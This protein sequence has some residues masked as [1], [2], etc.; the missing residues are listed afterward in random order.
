MQFQS[1]I[2]ILPG[3]GNSGLQHWQ[4]IWEKEYHFT[5]VEQ[6]DWDIPVCEDW[7]E[8]IHIEI[9]KH[10]PAEVILVAH[11]LACT[12]IA[13]WVQKFNIKIKG[14]LLV[15]PSDTEAATYPP[16]T[17]GFNPVPL[18]QLPFKTITVVSTNDYYVTLDRAEAF[19]A[20]WGSEVVNIGD[21]G[22]INAAAG[23]GEWEQGL[24]LLKSLDN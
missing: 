7:V 22:H 5:R 6:K 10:N 19:A 9:K 14:A 18:I 4:S 12:T 24:Q 1:T 17:I 13:Y 23:F 21:A 20:A 16:G 3:L 11:S 8:N 15:A 2:L